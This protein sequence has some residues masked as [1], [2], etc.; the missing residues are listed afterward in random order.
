MFYAMF[1]EIYLSGNIIIEQGE[2]GGDFY[3]IDQGEVNVN[4]TSI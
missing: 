3:I 4:E 1:P 2:N